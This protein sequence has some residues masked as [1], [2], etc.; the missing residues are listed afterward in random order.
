MIA[1]GTFT[2][3]MALIQ[4]R[5]RV[6]ALRPIGLL[7]QWNL[8]LWVAVPITLLGVFTFINLLLAW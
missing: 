5:R 4:H 8:A 2:M 6:A 1:I 3:V 7:P